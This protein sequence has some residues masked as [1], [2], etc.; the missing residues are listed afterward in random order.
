M[1][2]LDGYGNGPSESLFA[3]TTPGIAKRSY[4]VFVCDA[5]EFSLHALERGAAFGTPPRF[6]CIM[7]IW[8]QI[9]LK[10][11]VSGASCFS[12]EFRNMPALCVWCAVD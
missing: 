4:I 11:R 10:G 1:T 7:H 5:A 3:L 6:Q 9:W 12:K 2:F 8:S